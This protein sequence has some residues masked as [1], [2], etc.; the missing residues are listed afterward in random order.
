MCH[1]PPKMERLSRQ[2]P[3]TYRRSNGVSKLYSLHDDA[4]CCVNVGYAPCISYH[5]S[6]PIWLALQSREIVKEQ[7]ILVGLHFLMTSTTG[8]HSEARISRGVRASELTSSHTR[9]D[10]GSC[11]KRIHQSTSIQVSS[12]R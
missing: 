9:L 7:Y 4:D 5:E 8:T 10:P 1:G 2:D 3:V 6:S 12:L 11:R